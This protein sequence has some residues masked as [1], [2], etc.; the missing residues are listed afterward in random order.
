MLWML[1]KRE[2]TREKREEREIN[3][4]DAKL[5]NA[6]EPREWHCKAGVASK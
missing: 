1:K 2:E 6:G 4:S 3:G 5:A